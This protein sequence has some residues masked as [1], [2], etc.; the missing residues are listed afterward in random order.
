MSRK[1]IPTE[2]EFRCDG[3]ANEV[4]Q[5]GVEMPAGWVAITGNQ[6]TWSH[7]NNFHGLSAHACSKECALLVM[8]KLC[9]GERIPFELGENDASRR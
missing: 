3:C 1:E 5:R 4:R 2:W 7:T 8:T 9:D 6:I